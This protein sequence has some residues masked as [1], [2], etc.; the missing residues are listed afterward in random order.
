MKNTIKS[1]EDHDKTTR[2]DMNCTNCSK[3][4]IATIDFQLDGNHVILCPYCGHEHCRVVKKGKITGDRWDSRMQKRET[5]TQRL[6][7]SDSKKIQTSSIGHF[8][9]ESWLNKYGL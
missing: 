1:Y 5:S 6:W 9:R 7:T 8:I 4:F 2:T 3:N